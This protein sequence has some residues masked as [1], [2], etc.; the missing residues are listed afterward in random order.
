MVG[1]AQDPAAGATGP[2][3]TV[4][5]DV[6]PE[7]EVEDDE[8]PDD[9]GFDEDPAGEDADEG[10]VGSSKLVLFENWQPASSTAANVVA[11][12][13]QIFLIMS[14]YTFVCAH[15]VLARAV[16]SNPGKS[17]KTADAM[18]TVQEGCQGT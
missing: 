11:A 10:A 12:Q 14:V 1:D 7:E 16:N 18:V 6:D 3:V 17:G 13:T 15:T 8:A 4:P 5:P 9:V 2:P